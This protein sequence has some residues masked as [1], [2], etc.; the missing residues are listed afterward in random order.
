[1]QLGAL[2]Q[3]DFF[4]RMLRLQQM[5]DSY[6]RGAALYV[7]GIARLFQITEQAACRW[8]RFVSFRN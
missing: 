6:S 2:A 8:M 4:F 7:A 1:M 5:I 3:R